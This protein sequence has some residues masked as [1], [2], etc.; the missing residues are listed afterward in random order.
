MT[1]LSTVDGASSGVELQNVDHV[2]KAPEKI[3]DTKNDVNV[4]SGE[5]S[6][7]DTNLS[8]PNAEDSSYVML[9]SDDSWPEDES[10]LKETQQFTFRAVFVGSCLGGVIAASK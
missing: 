3:F 7:Y 2:G 6:R 5:V 4:E 9:S 8:D 10:G 1:F